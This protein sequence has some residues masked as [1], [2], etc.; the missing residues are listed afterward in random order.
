MAGGTRPPRRSYVVAQM[1]KKSSR[2][3]GQVVV[4][5]G[6]LDLRLDRFV[7]QPVQARAGFPVVDDPILGILCL[8]GFTNMSVKKILGSGKCGRSRAWRKILF[9]S[10]MLLVAHV[11]LRLD[12][13]DVGALVR[14]RS[15]TNTSC[16]SSP[17]EPVV[18]RAAMK[19]VVAG[20]APQHIITRDTVENIRILAALDRV[21]RGASDKVFRSDIRNGN[22][23]GLL[24]RGTR[25][26]PDEHLDRM[27]RFLL[28]IEPDAVLT[29][30]WDPT[31]SN[32]PPASS[33]SL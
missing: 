10:D 8:V 22:R 28:V 20:S 15:N 6:D 14:L 4:Q 17:Q 18:A 29:L 19:H 1:T 25:C 33:S 21:R 12:P 27:R 24:E 31:I 13:V 26:I 23:E 7:L 30:S 3:G 32:R 16:S 9:S 5:H 2:R 11:E